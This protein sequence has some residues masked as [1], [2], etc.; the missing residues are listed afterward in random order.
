MNIDEKVKYWVHISDKDIPVMEHL[1]ESGDYSYSLFIGHLA[2][3]KILK[4][5]FVK[6]IKET[7]PRTHDL[8][9]LAKL[10]SLDF[11]EEQLKFLINVNTF[12][13]EAR[14]P[15]EKLNFYK[16]CTYEFTTENIT[17]IKELHLW[18]KSLI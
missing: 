6:N 4:A 2:L 9:K 10:T 1:Y 18:L 7:P 5:H 3:E 8:F 15:D 17:Q 14:Y 13:M 11:S 12:N 16:I